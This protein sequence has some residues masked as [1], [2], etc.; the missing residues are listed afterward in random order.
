MD[1]RVRLLREHKME[2]TTLALSSEIFRAYDIRGI[3]DQTL[4]ESAVYWIARAFGSE[5]VERGISTVVV[6]RDG[7]LSG[8]RLLPIILR[9]LVDT[10][11]NVIN[12]DLVPTP[13]LYFAT[14]YFN[15]G[16]GIMLTGSHN[17]PDYNGLKMM[18]SGKTLSGDEILGL[19]HRIEEQAFVSGKGAVRAQTIHEPYR[20]RIAS[21]IQL[22]RPLKVVVDTGNG[23]AGVIVP[24]V[25][26]A[27]GANVIPLF[28]DVDGRFPN[29]H[30]DPSN[31][32]NM[33]VLIDTVLAEKA[34]IG[35]AFDGD[36]DRLGM[37]TEKG[38]IIWADRQLM[39]LAQDVLSRHPGAKIIY[40]VKCSSLLAEVI[41]QAGGEPIMA[42]TGHSLI[43]AKMRETGALLGG[44][45]SGHFFFQEDWYGF[46][47]GCYA[48]ARLLAMIALQSKPV[49]S[50]FDALPNAVN[51]PEIHIPLD[52]H[53]KFIF[54]KALI[55]KGNFPGGHLITLDGLRV[56]Y[57]YGWGLVRVSNTTPN[58]VCRFEADTQENLQKIQLQF[59]E[60][61]QA[62]DKNC[63]IPF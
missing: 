6:G 22:N 33:R 58:L 30:P 63:G 61:M 26:E 43:K 42:Q 20:E 48:A 47:D 31:P 9:G 38:E 37:V 50:F 29:H 17:P 51:T 5:A 52:D 40:D 41:K 21:C 53:K 2:T 54:V 25:L 13:E 10:G 39:L 44:E 16:T 35:L 18:M 19:K 12:I 56:E 8:P 1:I 3:V 55:E 27:I 14:H 45:M 46:D 34:D 57:S 60:Q 36:G 59:K 62:I 32:K 23:A 24:Q 28:C 49:S 15:T 7:R 11:I 4:T